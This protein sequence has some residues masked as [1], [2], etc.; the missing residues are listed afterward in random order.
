[1]LSSHFSEAQKKLQFIDKVYES[2][3]KT[4]QLFPDL[5]IEFD[6]LQENRNNYYAKLIHCNFD[7]TKSDLHDLDFLEEYNEFTLNEYAISTNIYPAY[8]HY[9]FQIPS[10]KIPGNYLL[11]LYR[12][13]DKS[14]IILSRRFFVVDNKITLQTENTFVGAGTLST[15]NQQLNFVL[16][17]GNIEILNPL[18]SVHVAVRQNQRWDN[19]R[20]DVKPSFV[21]DDRKELEYRFFEQDKHFTAGNEF[22][23]VDFR[24]LNFPGENTGKLDRSVKPF[25]LTVQHDKARTHQAYGQ[26]S[27]LNGGYRIENLDYGEAA[28]SGNYIETLFSLSAPTQINGDVYVIGSFNNWIRED[29]NRM[30]YNSTK[31]MYEATL[32]LKQ[33]LYNYVYS[34]ESPQLSPDY[35]EGSHYETENIYEVMVYYRPFRP[36]ADLL[37]GYFVLPVNPR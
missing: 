30:T 4:V 16:D 9:R 2:Q 6:D 26:Y 27:D 20:M 24:S 34:I 23:F 1:M 31:Q 5:S 7:W 10:V 28:V 15:S 33:G 8:V 14:D 22:R 18:E 13:G 3:I 19:A 35:F 12:D 36:N 37:I 21:R 29:E 11:I 17:Y 25:Q 32:Y